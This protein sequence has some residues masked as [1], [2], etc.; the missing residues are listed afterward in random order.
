[1]ATAGEYALNLLATLAPDFGTVQTLIDGKP[2]G[3]PVDLYAPLVLPSGSLSIGT[4]DLTAGTHTLAFRVT[5]KN[6]AS[7]DY[8]LGLDAFTLTAAQK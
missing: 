3:A 4:M 7:T 8:S 1:M 2:L 6:D 5:G